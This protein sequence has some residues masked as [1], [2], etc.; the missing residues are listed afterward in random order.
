MDGVLLINK[1]K[2]MTS[3]KVLTKIKHILN[4]D[5]IGH[6]GTLDPIST[7][8]LV[9]LLGK[10]TKLSRYLL[11]ENKCYKAKVLL[12]LRTD[13]FDI[14]GNVTGKK[15]NIK[16]TDF[17][18]DEVLNS[19]IG[20]IKQTPP[21][22]SAIKVGGKKLYEYARSGKD[23]EIEERTVE[24]YDLKRTSNLINNEFEFEVFASKGT[25]IRSL[26]DDIGI[27]LNTFATMLELERIKAGKFGILDCYNLLDIEKGNY[28]IISLQDALDLDSVTLNDNQYKKV[29]NGGKLSLKE[30]DKL[31]E[32]MM[33]L[34]EGEL[35]A[36]YHREEGFY[37]S[38]V[39][40]N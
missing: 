8:V 29:I 31:Y 1:E 26:I 37:K 33:L 6:C 34:Y 38:E 16:V 13:S 39:I 18:I 10:A 14:T 20:S 40:W 23:I 30:F 28:K 19:F 17:D 35:I 4:V 22:Y 27:K 3:Q 2:G 32:K 25:Y 12:G 36:I 15:D 11:E 21:I 5:K 24:I 9:C 7:G